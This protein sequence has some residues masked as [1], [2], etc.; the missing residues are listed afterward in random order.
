MKNE[1]ERSVTIPNRIVESI[2]ENI[3]KDVNLAEILWLLENKIENFGC[4]HLAIKAGLQYANIVITTYPFLLNSKLRERFFETMDIDLGNTTVIID[5]AH[6]LAKGIFGELSYKI[7]Y[8]AIKEIGQHPVLSELLKYKDKPGLHTIFFDQKAI[9]DLRNRGKHYLLDQMKSGY[10]DISFTLKVCD[11]L[12]NLEFCYLTADKKFTLFMKDPR[13][14]LDPLKLTK[15]IILLS[16]TFRP[17]KHFA[18]FL[19][20]PNASKITVLS[21]KISKNRI[22]LTTSDQ[23]LSMKYQ[24][25]SPD[26]FQY[27]GEQISKLIDAIPG[28]TLVFAPNYEL[29]TV[30]A[31]IVQANYV[32]QPNQPITKLI[33]EVKKATSKVVVVAPTRGKISEGIE[34]VKNDRSII[35][36]V[37]IA[38]LPYPPPSRSL[39]EIIK[40]YSKFWGEVR[41]TNYMNYLQ[42]VVT[43]RQALGRMIRSENDVG[44]W[45]IL[46][47]RISYM[48]VFPRS[49]ECKNVSKMVE[50]LDYF[51]KE[52]QL[53]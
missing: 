14:I 47:H 16:G 31:N 9:T 43:M 42:A 35:S 2:G 37:I 17:L 20:V 53:K 32:E 27:Y 26:R 12:N 21:E 24:T 44:A 30:L 52:H 45:I 38:G 40:E 48:D 39:R 10:R 46:D 7:V 25:R 50:R 34:F 4:P 19:G 15:Q 1:Y 23:Q 41:A 5:E 33:N 36:A 51:F 8:R 18:D 49:I 3:K 29:T 6:N 28:H 13:T 11:F 22:I